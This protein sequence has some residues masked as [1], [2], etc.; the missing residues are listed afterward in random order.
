MAK[1]PLT[2]QKCCHTMIVVL[3]NKIKAVIYRALPIKGLDLSE[4]TLDKII[5]KNYDR[6]VGEPKPVDMSAV[7][8]AAHRVILDIGDSEEEALAKARNTLLEILEHM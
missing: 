5:H 1:S 2:A 6:F 4:K 3:R 7:C 8:A